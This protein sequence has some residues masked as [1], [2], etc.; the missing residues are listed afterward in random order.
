MNFTTTDEDDV[1]PVYFATKAEFNDPEWRERFSANYPGVRV[2]EV[3]PI[4]IK[5]SAR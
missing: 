5:R 2:V 1:Y 3:K 4:P